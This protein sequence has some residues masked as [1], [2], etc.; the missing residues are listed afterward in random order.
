MKHLK[1]ITV[2]VIMLGLLLGGFMSMAAKENKEQKVVKDEKH[3]LKMA[4]LDALLMMESEKAIPV[5]K[6]IL[7]KKDFE[8]RKK[9]VFILSQK[10]PKVAIPILKKIALTD[11]DP[12]IKENAIFWLGQTDSDECVD[13]LIDIYDKSNGSNTKKKVLFSLSQMDKPKAFNKLK[14]VAAN[15]KDESLCGEALFWLGES[16]SKD[17]LKIYSDVLEGNAGLAIQ[18]KALSG[19]TR[20]DHAEA[21]P[22]LIKVAKTHKS[23]ELKK[24][25]IFWLGQSNDPRVANILLELIDEK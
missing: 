9:A 25:A 15:K 17:V 12:E 23:K 2:V 5:L 16:G 19:L 3:E 8:M 14:E 11:S 7:D 6:K 20:Y 4:A 21:I 22:L 24:E 10:D 18:K 1:G 13:I